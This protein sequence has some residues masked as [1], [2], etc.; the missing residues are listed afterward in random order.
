MLLIPFVYKFKN[1]IIW[2][3][4][5]SAF[6]LPFFT[7][8]FSI[9][10]VISLSIV[11]TVCDFQLTLLFQE[12]LLWF[13]LE[14]YSFAII[15][16]TQSHRCYFM[17]EQRHCRHSLWSV[18]GFWASSLRLKLFFHGFIGFFLRVSSISVRTNFPY[19]SEFHSGT[20]QWS[21]YQIHLA[22]VCRNY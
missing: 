20:H 8:K 1:I 5:V 10:T 16:D 17:C 13:L 15:R 18:Y 6:N 19:R 4:F 12:F 11:V 2:F 21:Q 9:L 7:L 14:D 3:R 22:S